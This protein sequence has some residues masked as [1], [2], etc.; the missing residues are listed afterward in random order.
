MHGLG[1]IGDNLQKRKK[2]CQICHNL[3]QEKNIKTFLFLKKS[4]N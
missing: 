1:T 4:I 3:N 2:K